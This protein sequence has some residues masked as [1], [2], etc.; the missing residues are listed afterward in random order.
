[1]KMEQI[2]CFEKLALKLQTHKKAY[3]IQDTA[4]FWNQEYCMFV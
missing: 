2:E 1:M 3:N 4:K